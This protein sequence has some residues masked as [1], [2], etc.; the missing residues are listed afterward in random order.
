MK[1]LACTSNARI[2]ATDGKRNVKFIKTFK[3][4]DSIFNVKFETTIMQ[5]FMQLKSLFK[6]QI[7]KWVAGL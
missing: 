6:K 5:A 4:I 1:G 7:G 2:A 3:N